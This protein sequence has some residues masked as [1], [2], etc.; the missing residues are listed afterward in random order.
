MGGHYENPKRN[1]Y[2]PDFCIED[3]QITRDNFSPDLVKRPD[4]WYRMIEIAENLSKPFKHCRVDLYNID[5]KI[6]F[7][8]ITF[9]HAGGCNIIKPQEKQLEYGS[10][11]KL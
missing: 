1:I 6:Y 4:G 2:S 7:G 8:E 5:G 11:I 10:Y 3:V 9:H